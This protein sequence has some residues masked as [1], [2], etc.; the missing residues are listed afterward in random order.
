MPTVIL[1]RPHNHQRRQ[2]SAGAEIKVS[3]PDAEFI[4]A[5]GAGEI[6]SQPART[7]PTAKTSRQQGR[8]KPKE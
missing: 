2:Y 5:R 8:A 7:A 6:V 1:K 3:A 4:V